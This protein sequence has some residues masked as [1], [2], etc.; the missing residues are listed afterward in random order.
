MP[1]LMITE[2]ALVFQKIRV[3]FARN[4]IL[5]SIP[6]SPDTIDDTVP[7]ILNAAYWDTILKHRLN[8]LKQQAASKDEQLSTDEL[9]DKC[10]EVLKEGRIANSQRSIVGLF[11]KFDSYVLERMV[12]TANYRQMLNHESKDAFHFG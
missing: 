4:V 1:V 7:E 5:Y 12:G 8:K 2:R 11:T 3:R 6:E 9:T 10:K